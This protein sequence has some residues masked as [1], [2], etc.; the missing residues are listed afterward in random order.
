MEGYG[1]GGLTFNTQW[2]FPSRLSQGKKPSVSCRASSF[3][4][5][6][7]MLLIFLLLFC[8]YFFFYFFR[9]VL[10]TNPLVYASHTVPIFFA[11]KTKTSCNLGR[12]LQVLP[13]PLL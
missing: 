11:G 3:L 5:T 8:L 7:Y 12:V 2:K 4:Y 13:L 6:C 9:K 1:L 10:E